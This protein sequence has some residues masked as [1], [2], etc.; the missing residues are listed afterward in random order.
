M[1]NASNNAIEDG[2]AIC[3]KGY[4]RI[5]SIT[6]LRHAE[7]GGNPLATGYNRLIVCF[8]GQNSRMINDSE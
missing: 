1:E 7:D 6:S 3:V 2:S 8:G 4:F 5:G